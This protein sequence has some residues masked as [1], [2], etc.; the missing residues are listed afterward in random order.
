MFFKLE[1]TGDV[2]VLFEGEMLVGVKPTQWTRENNS[3]QRPYTVYDDALFKTKGGKFL[4]QTRHS[5]GYGMAYLRGFH[6]D[7]DRMT[8]HEIIGLMG[9]FDAAKDVLKALGKTTERVIE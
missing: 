6:C 3:K 5:R 4:L 1:P 2:P 7:A 9:G 8:A